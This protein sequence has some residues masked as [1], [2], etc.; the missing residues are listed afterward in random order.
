MAI[1]TVPLPL[2]DTSGYTV[3]KGASLSVVSTLTLDA[4]AAAPN[5]V[6]LRMSTVKVV[7]IFGLVPV[8]ARV[9]YAASG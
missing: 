1:I 4:S 9:T 2:L 6:A 7:T 3:A 5:K 8:S